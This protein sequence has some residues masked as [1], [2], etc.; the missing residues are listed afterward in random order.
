MNIA[1]FVHNLNDPAVHRRVRM[2]HSGGAKI[3]L[4]GFFRGEPPGPVE[5]CAPILLGRTHDARLLQRAAATAMAAFGNG[6]L[7]S[8]LADA[9]VVMARQLELLAIAARAR[10]RLAPSATLVYECLDIHRLMIARGAVGRALRLLEGRL[11]RQCQLLVVSS[12]GFVREYFSKFHRSL[13]PVLIL[14]N[15][16]LSQ[17]IGYTSASHALACPPAPP[18]RIGWFGNV[19]C[20]RSLIMLSELTRLFPGKVE[21]LI[22][23]RPAYTA[24]PDFDEKVAA[25]PGIT[26][27]G[28]Y[29][30]SRDLPR[31]YGEVHFAWAIDFFEAGG[32]AEWL[33][34]NR[35]YEGSM[36]GVVTLALASVE[37]GRWLADHGVGALLSEPLE[38]SLVRFFQGLDENGYLA[39]RTAVQG[40]PS[41]ALMDSASDCERLVRTLGQPV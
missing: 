30:R 3:T 29:D 16:V 12:A 9:D 14:E 35:I 7:R 40:L 36:F 17:E 4:I 21:V 27:L 11:L 38:S 37:T 28:P 5:G 24:I 10:R 31:I 22:R 6:R 26:F 15:K 32:N 13:P 23:G 33:L 39:A 20:R 41:E 25:H 34:P 8:I 19:R 2:L 1:Y 18:W